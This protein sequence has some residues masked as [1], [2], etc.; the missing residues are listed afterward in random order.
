M[1]STYIIGTAAAHPVSPTPLSV[2]S[3]ATEKSECEHLSAYVATDTAAKPP[4]SMSCQSLD[5]PGPSNQAAD[6][7]G[8]DSSFQSY[9]PPFGIKH[10]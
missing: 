1:V 5:E 9:S 7:V 6:T 2:Q 3:L 10:S 4:S 8:E